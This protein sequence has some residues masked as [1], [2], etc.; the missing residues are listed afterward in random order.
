MKV[1]NTKIVA[2]DY[3]ITREPNEYFLEY[4]SL[5]AATLADTR[6]GFIAKFFS[7]TS[8]KQDYFVCLDYDQAE[9]LY[10]LLKQ[11]LKDQ[12]KEYE[13]KL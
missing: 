4:C 11:A 13:A 5:P 2:D 7:H 9:E 12:K 8:Y 3:E 6:N 10:L 1:G